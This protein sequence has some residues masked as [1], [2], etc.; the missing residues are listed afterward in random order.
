MNPNSKA[1]KQQFPIPKLEHRPKFNKCYCVNTF[2]PSA[3]VQNIFTFVL[4]TSPLVKFSSC[5]GNYR[6][7]YELL[8]GQTANEKGLISSVY[9]KTFT[10]PFKYKKTLFKN[11]H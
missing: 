3:Y 6:F 2:I 1:T 9:K 10:F 7:S 11:K 4:I 5:D 8:L